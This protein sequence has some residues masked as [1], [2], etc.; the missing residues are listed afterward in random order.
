ME[1]NICE[2]I[3]SQHGNLALVT[4]ASSGIGHQMALTLAKAGAN[5]V[6]VARREDRLKQLVSEIEAMG[7]K[8]YAIVA[9][10]S[11]DE[12]I[13]ELL[14][15]VKSQ[16]PRIDVLINNAGLGKLTP[17]GSDDHMRS[18]KFWDLSFQVNLRA[19]WRIIDGLA[20]HLIQQKTPV[21]IINVA[22]ICGLHSVMKS[23][24][25]YCAS[26]SALIQ[27]TRSLVH[28]LSPHGI[29]INAIAPGFIA[30]EMTED[31]EK[32]PTLLKKIP[33][34]R[35]G[36]CKDLDGLLLYLA[37]NKAS[38]YATGSIYTVD[39]GISVNDLTSL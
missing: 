24:T 29:R 33:L 23:L 7:R 8:A 9:D 34:G 20:Q 25:A 19:P 28:E 5:L 30:T 13:D 10:L 38:S 17:V 3:F 32:H 39:G 15:K 35:L 37:S 6:V 22:S 14:N 31:I 16:C 36:Q 12:S 18:T 4:G 26:K 11:R 21:S 27:M 2:E 1:K